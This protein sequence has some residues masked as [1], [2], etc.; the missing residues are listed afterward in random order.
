MPAARPPLAEVIP[1]H[2]VPAPLL[3]VDPDTGERWHVPV[4]PIS[5]L[6]ADVAERWFVNVAIPLDLAEAII[7]TPFLR[8]DAIAGQA[9]LSLCRIRM[10]HGAP[11]WAPLAL[12]PASDNV[13]LRIGCRDRRDGSPAV[14]VDRRCTTH[15]LGR[16][17]PV[18]GFP[19][20]EPCLRVRRSDE[21][22]LDLATTDDALACAVAPGTAPPPTL[23]ADAAALT[24]W[25]T[26]GV[27][28]YAPDGRGGYRVADLEKGS[29]NAFALR[30]GW[31]GWLRTPWGAW[32]SDGV[33][34]T[35]DGVYQWRVLG[36]VDGHGRPC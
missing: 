19:P 31:A 36:R 21:A 10:R 24:E 22:G 15:V 3:V 14:W 13:A 28:S 29:P 17:L 20:V 18:L 34:R 11:D 33:Y 16:I 1:M 7:A 27:R 26:A 8:P 25:V 5:R 12:G 23:F 30:A 4:Q 9:V 35:C 32:P 2:P 6:D